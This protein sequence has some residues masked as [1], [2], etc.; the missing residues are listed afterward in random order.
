LG[1]K[2]LAL[3]KKEDPALA[4]NM[5]DALK[6]VFLYFDYFNWIVFKGKSSGNEIVYSQ[7]LPYKSLISEQTI[8]KIRQGNRIKVTDDKITVYQNK[9][10]IF[11]IPKKDKHKGVVMDFS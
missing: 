7:V 1:K 5:V 8:D 4:K 10:I 11:K 2:T 9:K 6:N 3:I